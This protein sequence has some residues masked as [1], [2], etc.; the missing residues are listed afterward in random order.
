MVLWQMNSQLEK[1][2]LDGSLPH[3][4]L[5][6]SRWIK[7]LNIKKRRRKRKEND[8]TEFQKEE[9]LK[10]SWS[11]RALSMPENQIITTVKLHYMKIKKYV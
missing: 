6:N 5:I 4:T 11:G 2:K 8:K 9:L 1:N 7:K 3:S 10:Q